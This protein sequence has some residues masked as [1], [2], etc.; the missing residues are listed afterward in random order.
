MTSVQKNP[1]VGNV[2][3]ILVGAILWTLFFIRVFF[4]ETAWNDTFL[5][6]PYQIFINLISSI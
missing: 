1:V 6:R 5:V 3:K 2:N 4:N